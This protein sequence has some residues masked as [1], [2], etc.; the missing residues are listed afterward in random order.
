MSNQHPDFVLPKDFCAN[1][2]EAY[3]IPAYFYTQQAAFEHEKE[4]VFTNSWIC[5]AHGSEV[6]QLMIT[7][8]VRLLVRTSLSCVDVIA[9]CG[10]FI[11]SVRIVGTNY[12]VG[13][14]K[15]RMSLL[16]P[17]MPG[18]SSSTVNWHM[19]VTA[20]MSL[21][22]IKIGRRFSRCA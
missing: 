8:L 4:R 12:S 14:V 6:A 1:P 15:Q 18:P 17:I 9:Y 16:A 3:T 20:R 22:L 7:S 19:P 21:I 5:M 2:R 10:L 11:M 13:K